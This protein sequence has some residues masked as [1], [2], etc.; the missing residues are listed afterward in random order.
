MPIGKLAEFLKARATALRDES[1]TRDEAAARE[2]REAVDE[3]LTQME[4]WVR[5]A[6]PD[7]LLRVRRFTFSQIERKLGY[8]ETPALEI[9]AGHECVVICP[10]A[11]YVAGGAAVPGETVAEIEGAINFGARYSAHYQLCRVKFGEKYRW[12]IQDRYHIDKKFPWIAAPFDR[13]AF[14]TAMVSL[15]R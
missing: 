5:A 2:W 4:E 1:R 8:Y 15:L 14:E 9:I 13:E 10:W 11:R 7:A 6:D 12:L 3:I